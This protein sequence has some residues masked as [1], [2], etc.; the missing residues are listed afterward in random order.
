M[1]VSV[2]AARSAS[3]TLRREVPWAPLALALASAGAHGLLL[4]WPYYSS[5]RLSSGAAA[6]LLERPE[7]LGSLLAFAAVLTVFFMP[8][9]AIGAAIWAGTWA[10]LEWELLDHHGRRLLVAAMLVAG[11]VF[12]FRLTPL[13]NAVANWWID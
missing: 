3:C 12:A 5:D 2:A 13:A 7:S 1:R 6:W 4:V 9:L 8:L 10:V 11:A